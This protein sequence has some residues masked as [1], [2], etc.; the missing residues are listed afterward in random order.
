MSAAAASGDTELQC[1]HGQREGS[2][3]RS[4]R[5]S[6]GFPGGSGEVRQN[7][8]LPAVSQVETETLLSVPEAFLTGL[9]GGV[10]EKMEFL[11]IVA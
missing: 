10:S 8:P 6:V 9:W 5:C 1:E 7:Q 4:E 3:G 2:G 11:A